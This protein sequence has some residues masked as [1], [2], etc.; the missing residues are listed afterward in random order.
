MLA[1]RELTR[2]TDTKFVIASAQ[3]GE[4]LRALV[5]DF[6]VLL[7]G[8]ARIASYRTLYFDTANLDFFDAHLHGRR[9]RHKARI[10]HYPDRRLSTLEVRIRRS[11][12]GTVKCRIA[13]PIDVSERSAD[14]GAFVSLH[15]GF[16]QDLRPQAWTNFRRITLLGLSTQE[17]VTIDLDLAFE[18]NG[19][20]RSLDSTAIVE[21]KRWPFWPRTAVLSAMRA[22]G[23]RRRTLSKYCTAIALCRHELNLNRMLPILRDLERSTA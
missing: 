17:R 2:R 6:A 11:E 15:T 4:L 18:V 23:W 7:A 9:V 1:P 3:V 21:V 13:H 12:I 5:D 14:D 10:R 20:R 16:S 19:I 22:G 8:R